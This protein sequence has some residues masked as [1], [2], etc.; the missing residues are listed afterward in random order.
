MQARAFCGMFVNKAQCCLQLQMPM[1]AGSV[2]CSPQCPGG[3]Q[4]S[5]CPS[6]TR[7]V[8]LVM[9]CAGQ[10]AS[11]FLSVTLCAA[12]NSGQMASWVGVRGPKTG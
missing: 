11:S 12:P 7:G 8:T 3:T 5:A 2:L 10:G 1:C 9:F 4:A 6:L